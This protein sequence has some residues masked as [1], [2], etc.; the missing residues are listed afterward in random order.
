MLAAVLEKAGRY[1]VEYERVFRDIA[2]EED[3]RQ[4]SPGAGA[5]EAAAWRRT[6]ADVVFAHLPPPI[7]WGSFRDVFELN[8]QEVRGR[9]ARLERLFR[10]NPGSAVARAE[11]ILAE[12]ARYNIGPQRTVNLP[13]LP[14]LFL[15][16]QN[17][18][19]F[20]FELK[21]PKEGAAESVE[22]AFRE[23]T[24]PTIV[25]DRRID[26]G[27]ERGND[28]PAQGR[29]PWIDPRRGTVLRSE[30]VFRFRPAESRAAITTEYRVEPRLTV[31]VPA[32]MRERYEGPD[33]DGVTEAVALYSGFRQFQVTTSE[34]A[35]RLPP[36]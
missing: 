1:V 20:S 19:R 36:R 25:R 3:Y 16:P 17:Q 10:D 14:L 2:A 18:A 24:R 12:S 28:L 8:G 32:E 35:V 21:R 9:D 30:V 33:F 27:R 15:H 5:G 26:R 11:A 13:T 4:R 29:L 34:G 22:L 31:W 23:V 7:P 6:R